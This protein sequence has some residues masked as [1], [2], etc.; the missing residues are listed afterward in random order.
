MM[1]PEVKRLKEQ[2]KHMEQEI[3]SLKGQIATGQHDYSSTVIPASYSHKHRLSAISNLSKLAGTGIDI[4]GEV[5][6]TADDEIDHDALN[7]FVA[8][9]HI[10]WTNAA[11]NFMTSGTATLNGVV[12]IG[13]VK[14]NLANGTTYYLDDDGDAVLKDL[15]LSTTL[16]IGEADDPDIYFKDSKSGDAP[17]WSVTHAD[18]YFGKLNWWTSD[19]NAV[20][21]FIAAQNANVGSTTPHAN[22]VFHCGNSAT[23]SEKLRISYDGSIILPYLGAAPGT[24]ANG[25][26]W[27]E[28]DGLHIYY[29]G[30]EKVVAGA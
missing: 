25:A 6:S 8:N 22:L 26:I 19:P 20:F 12:Q 29:N 30:A 7:N 15:I 17:Y 5:L 14:V 2:L 9:E 3:L 11:A 10:D 18:E 21:A 16:N 4:T 13:A 28:A 24:A 1:L 23:I 27:M